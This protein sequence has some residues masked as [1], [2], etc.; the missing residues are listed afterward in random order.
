L[1]TELTI[2]DALDLKVQAV[3]DA[4]APEHPYFHPLVS[5]QAEVH[6]IEGEIAAAGRGEKAGL[7]ASLVIP[8]TRGRRWL[9]RSNLAR[10]RLRAQSRNWKSFD[11]RRTM[12]KSR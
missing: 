3:K 1:Q 2:L 10:S 11:R 7:K 12:A 6:R 4:I 5:L 9:T 8:K